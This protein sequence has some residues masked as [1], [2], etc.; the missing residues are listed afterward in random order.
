LL[1]RRNPREERAVDQAG[2]RPRREQR[3]PGGQ[4][5]DERVPEGRAAAYVLS[6]QP[7]DAIGDG[8]RERE[9]K[10]PRA[11][12]E[13]GPPVQRNQPELDQQH[14]Q[15]KTGQDGLGC[16]H[17]AA[18]DGEPGATRNYWWRELYRDRRQQCRRQGRYVI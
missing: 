8:S 6:G 15:R 12:T 13:R 2:D 16:V 14:Q 11:R 3:E 18:I 5:T 4:E 1:G 7:V 17:P 9:Q 10:C